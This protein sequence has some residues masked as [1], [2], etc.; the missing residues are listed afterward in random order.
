MAYRL[1]DTD[2]WKNPWFRKIPGKY[3]L[4]F[5]YMLDNC[6][7]A[8]VMH[9]DFEAISFLIKEEYEL[10]SFKEY[11]GKQVVFLADDKVIIKSFIVHQKNKG[12]QYM[13]KNISKL[14]DKHGV[15]D[16]YKNGEF[17]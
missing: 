1:S 7:N 2:K 11:L 9:I 12:N 3:K 8:G 6:D 16:R 10:D 14:L 15:L 4:L 13:E 17:G 5:L